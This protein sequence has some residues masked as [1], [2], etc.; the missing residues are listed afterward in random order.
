MRDDHVER[1]A[2]LLDRI[3][4]CG[5]RPSLLQT[6]LLPSVDARRSPCAPL[7]G[8]SIC[9]RYADVARSDHRAPSFSRSPTRSGAK[10]AEP[11]GLHEGLVNRA[12]PST[13]LPSSQLTERANSPRGGDAKPGS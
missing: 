3:G 6:W 7:G 5:L 11:E 4:R 13:I 1:Q 2:Q 12:P 8:S 10:A 9:R